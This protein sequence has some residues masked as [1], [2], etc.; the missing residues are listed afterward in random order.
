MISC[1]AIYLSLIIWALNSFIH[2]LHFI[3]EGVEKQFAAGYHHFAARTSAQQSLF[4][5]A[6]VTY[7]C[8]SIQ[9]SRSTMLASLSDTVSAVAVAGSIALILLSHRYSPHLPLHP[10]VLRLLDS[11]HLPMTLLLALAPHRLF[12]HL[13]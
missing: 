12:L 11:N 1:D 3:L 9:S 13:H 4:K 8:N 7:A 2:S 6:H 10:S 5:R